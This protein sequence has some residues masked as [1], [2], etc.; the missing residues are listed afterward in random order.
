MKV[1]ICDD[2]PESF[3]TAV[4]DAYFEKDG[5]ITSA[6][7]F[8]LS[9][10]VEI[11]RVSADPVKCGKVVKGLN[12]YDKGALSDCLLA[13]RSCD[14]QKMQSVFA[15]IRKIFEKKATV[16]NA[17]NLAEVVEFNALTYKITGE[18][19]RLKGLLRFKETANGTFYAPYSPDNDITGLLMPHFAERFKTEN[20]VIHDIGRKIAGIYNRREW[21]LVSADEAEICLSDGEKAFE[22]LWKKYYKSV[23]IQ[24]RPHEKQMKR[25]MPTR[26][27]KFLPERFD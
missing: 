15:Y 25:S 26:Y 1:F 7:N 11:V 5:I 19:H 21:I 18:I 16:A 3:F 22:A 23:N 14:G 17:Y 8:Q 2:E 24:S 20:F 9:L 4:F 13:L 12:K 6:E 27:W 10:G